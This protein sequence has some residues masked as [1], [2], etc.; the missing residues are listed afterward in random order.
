MNRS[1]DPR[2]RIA[3]PL[4]TGLFLIAALAG[5]AACNSGG[6]VSG[7]APSSATGSVLSAVQLASPRPEYAG[8]RPQPLA[9]IAID[10]R[11]YM[12][13]TVGGNI[14]NPTNMMCT[15]KNGVATA[16]CIMG[17]RDTDSGE[18]DIYYDHSNGIVDHIAVT[19]WKHG[20]TQDQNSREY[21]GVIRNYTGST[22]ASG[23]F[24]RCFST[25][26]SGA[27][28]CTDGVYPSA[29][30]MPEGTPYKFNVDLPVLGNK[31]VVDASNSDGSPKNPIQG[32]L[33]ITKLA[34]EDN[35]FSFAQWKQT[36]SNCQ[37]YGSSGPFKTKVFVA[38]VQNVPFGGT[39]IVSGGSQVQQAVGTQ[40]AFVVDTFSATEAERYFYVKDL[41]R[42]RE[43]HAK[44]DSACGCFDLNTL[45]VDHGDIVPFRNSVI[46]VRGQSQHPN[47][48][49]YCPEG[50]AQKL[51][52]YTRSQSQVR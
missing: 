23:A 15:D 43:G 38:Y 1:F 33:L 3:R 19:D 41:G 35:Y 13:G 40:D 48:E 52:G 6:S 5:F 49:P 27:Q 32:A 17:V 22:A 14:H 24:E 18:V 10:V 29:F 9:T 36:N 42:V 30:Y 34:S 44:F 45:N 28:F 4:A 20:T 12:A 25:W 47:P 51:W 50:S 16:I 37:T 26:L 2:Q 46:Y 21:I 39:T 11:G 8:R 31:A 7:E